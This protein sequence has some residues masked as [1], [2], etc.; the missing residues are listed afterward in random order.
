M[1]F[2]DG[3]TFIRLSRLVTAYYRARSSITRHTVGR[4]VIA[5]IA[6]SNDD[7]DGGGGGDVEHTLGTSDTDGHTAD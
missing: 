6:S 5:S 1:H 2:N 4:S 3:F 7:Y